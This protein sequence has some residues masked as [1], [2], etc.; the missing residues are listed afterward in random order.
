MTGRAIGRRS[1]LVLPLALV[2]ASS[3][4]LALDAGDRTLNGQRVGAIVKATPPGDLAKIYGAERVAAIKLN[5]EGEEYP[6]VSIHAGT[7]D[8]LR[9][10]F[11]ADSKRIRFV[12]VIGR[13]WKTT[14]GVRLGTTLA[15]LERINGGPFNFN[16]FGWDLGGIVLDQ[17]RT[18]FAGGGLRVGLETFKR[19]Q[20]AIRKLPN[21]RAPISAVARGSAL[22]ERGIRGQ[23]H[24]RVGGRRGLRQGS[25]EGQREFLGTRIDSRTRN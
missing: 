5:E 7:A 9:V 4:A 1:L 10:A 14:L 20:V 2:L 15:E 11:T 18:K 13:N 12:R 3:P 24:D 8:E 6:G 22:G 21:V 19:L 25:A 16:G 17:P 23:D